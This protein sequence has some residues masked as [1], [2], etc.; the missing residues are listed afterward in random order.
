M[1]VPVALAAVAVI[2]WL[3][4]S[5]RRGRK[6]G[7]RHG[8]P[9]DF[10][11]DAHEKPF[12]T[13]GFVAPHDQNRMSKAPSEIDSHEIRFPIKPQDTAYMAS[14]NHN[15]YRDQTTNTLY[16][17]AQPNYSN[18]VSPTLPTSTSS[19]F[20]H[21]SQDYSEWAVTPR[22]QQHQRWSGTTA[23]EGAVSVGMRSEDGGNVGAGGA[24]G[25]PAHAHELMGRPQIPPTIHEMP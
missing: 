14:S 13:D 2:G 15:F 9:L 8:T 21:P 24:N 19:N 18:T 16:P 1:G 4:Y 10:S 23:Q 17:N 7:P 3:F 11:P 12:A 20:S 25:G 6:N 22:L 5:R